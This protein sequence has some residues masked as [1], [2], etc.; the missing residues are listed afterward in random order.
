MPRSRHACRRSPR[1]PWLLTAVHMRPAMA[2]LTHPGPPVFVYACVCVCA[3]TC[4][5]VCVY[6]CVFVCVQ[7]YTS[8]DGRKCFNACTTATSIYCKNHTCSA[9]GCT[10]VD[11]LPCFLSS[12]APAP[13]RKTSRCCLATLPWCGRHT[14]LR[15]I[16][17]LACSRS[18]QLA[19]RSRRGRAAHL[20]PALAWL[21]SGLRPVSP[22]R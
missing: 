5:C 11:L 6:L 1:S 16:V 10:E 14:P 22:A 2:D 19:Q 8:D 20:P 17:Q 15:G 7:R 3:R 12:P 4:V 13:H 9:Q 18:V 21:S